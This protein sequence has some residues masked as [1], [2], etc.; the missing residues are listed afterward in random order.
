LR[1]FVGER[2]A[3]QMRGPHD[4]FHRREVD[5]LHRIGHLT[6]SG[7]KPGPPHHRN[8]AHHE[9]KLGAAEEHIQRRSH[10]WC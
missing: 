1:W 10:F 6:V 2:S 8:V 5:F 7:L 9:G 4:L 3:G